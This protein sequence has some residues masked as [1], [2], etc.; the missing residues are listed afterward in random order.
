MSRGRAA[1]AGAVGAVVWGVAEPLDKALLRHDYSDIALLGKTITRGRGWRVAG[2]AWHAANGA[3][4]G[5]ALDAIQ[6]RTGVDRRA[7]GVGLALAEN[8]VL[9]P[10]TILLDRYHPA[11]GEPGLAPMWSRRAYA[12]SMWRHALFGYVVARLS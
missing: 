6:R 1:A 9:Y 12:Q 10:L 5:V 7:L 2:F 4:F 3:G 11:R 8:T